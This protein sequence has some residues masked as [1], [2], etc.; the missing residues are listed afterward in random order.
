MRRCVLL[1]L[2][3]DLK[4]R[5]IAS[6]M[7]ISIDTVKAHLFQARQ[8]LK[9]KLSRYFRDQDYEDHDQSGASA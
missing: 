2:E 4:Y 9:D 3:Q 8:L 6:V 5:E 1:R 7:Q